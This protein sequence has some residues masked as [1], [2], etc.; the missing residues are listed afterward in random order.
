M[1]SPKSVKRSKKEIAKCKKSSLDMF[2]EVLMEEMLNKYESLVK[3]LSSR[4]IYCEIIPK[5]YQRMDSDELFG[6][7]FSETSGV[8][9]SK[10]FS[11][12][13][14]NHMILT[15]MESYINCEEY[16]FDAVF[17]TLCH[18]NLAL[19]WIL[20]QAADQRNKVNIKDAKCQFQNLQTCKQHDKVLSM[21]NF[22]WHQ[23]N[24]EYLHWKYSAV[25]YEM[26]LLKKM[27]V[28]EKIKYRKT[29]LVTK[30]K[31]IH[32]LKNLIVHRNI[33]A[34][35][36]RTETYLS[37]GRQIG[38]K[39]TKLR[40][41]VQSLRKALL[42]D[43]DGEKSSESKHSKDTWIV[44]S[45]D[46]RVE[47][48]GMAELARLKLFIEKYKRE[49][50]ILQFK[51]NQ[52]CE[53]IDE[54]VR[55]KKGNFP[56]CQAMIIKQLDV[57]KLLNIMKDDHMIEKIFSKMFNPTLLLI[58]P[59][60][61]AMSNLHNCIRQINA[62]GIIKKQKEMQEQDCKIDQLE[63]KIIRHII[64][65]PTTASIVQNEET[66]STH[67]NATI[68]DTNSNE[69][70]P[71]HD[72]KYQK[73]IKRENGKKNVY[74]EEF[75][76]ILMQCVEEY[77]QNEKLKKQNAEWKTQVTKLRE[78]RS[79]FLKRGLDEEDVTKYETTLNMLTSDMLKLKT[80]DKY[81][82]K[83]ERLGKASHQIITLLNKLMLDRLA[84]EENLN[85]LNNT[86]TNPRSLHDWS[87]NKSVQ[88]CDNCKLN[89][90]K[91]ADCAKYLTQILYDENF[92]RF[93]ILTTVIQQLTA[94]L[95]MM[96]KSLRTENMSPKNQL[97]CK[98][99]KRRLTVMKNQLRERIK[100]KRDVINFTSAGDS[101]VPSS[102]ANILSPNRNEKADKENYNDN[103]PDSSTVSHSDSLDDKN[104]SKERSNIDVNQ[105]PTN[106]LFEQEQEMTENS[107]SNPLQQTC[108]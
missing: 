104:I 47:T 9:F 38:I 67:S 40:N 90:L 48:E 49:I 24:I 94:I 95:C 102:E 107:S 93:Y 56:R 86:A 33:E 4:N 20:P 68:N 73:N 75:R 2:N 16:N 88:Q 76:N 26:I 108:E 58:N 14:K 32:I 66:N 83:R 36:E 29:E 61:N 53:N 55:E 50:Q 62:T 3:N 27:S 92:I 74:K 51:I 1:S 89:F 45:I 54:N 71:L 87:I 70:G 34:K 19:P 57:V 18:Y 44:K 63:M 91:I 11:S 99:L 97:L 98:K 105:T 43:E 42:D 25:K 17:D 96:N 35:R 52:L 72:S 15:D 30:I 69:Q 59:I 10:V 23:T 100:V 81:K 6:E 82:N 80:Y 46:W 37:C 28:D 77:Q 78:A 8:T 106:V 101:N 64:G 31:Y 12:A 22:R 79:E 7:A 13:Y 5:Q 41:E 103:N 65:G 85:N 21:S 39:L 84:V 60:T